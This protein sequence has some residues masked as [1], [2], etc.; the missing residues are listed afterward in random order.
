MLDQQRPKG[1]EW[2]IVLL[3]AIT[4]GMVG[5]DR[6][7]IVYLFP[8]IIPEFNLSNT[9]AGAI[10]S[11]LALT[12]AV[13]AWVLGNVS[14]K[15]GRKKVL[16]PSIIFFSLMSWVTALSK[17]LGSMLV[18][19]GLLGFGEGGVFSATVASI[20]EESSPKR[21]GLNIGF[22]QSFFPLMGIGL[23]AI[24]ATQLAQIFSWRPVFFIV[25][26]PGII[27][28]IIIIFYMREPRSTLRNTESPS[29]SE[30]ESVGEKDAEKLGLFA[31]FKYRNIWLSTVISCLF[32]N[33][34]F[35]F[36]AFS[37]LFLTEIRGLSLTSVGL[38]LSGWGFGGFIGMILIPAL[39]DFIGRRPTMVI[40][41]IIGGITTLLFAVADPNASL[42]FFILLIA[43]IFGWG[44]Y[45]LF[46]A[47]ITTESVPAKMAGTAV[48]I[49]TAI[50][51]IFGAMLMPIIA[52]GLAD[53]YGLSYPMFLAG[54]APIIV[55]IIA[56]FYIETA[57]RIVARKKGVEKADAAV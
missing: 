43:G 22:F 25:G 37:P 48:G 46:L 5:L 45:P 15:Y 38:I 56:L 32:M 10:T 26:I 11:V 29:S 55:G 52:G 6:L 2:K 21:K 30:S 8:I 9:A 18:I 51:E 54:A 33:W 19:R 20:A 50:G 27:L 13:A 7:V 53:M 39:S 31:P 28:A 34:L 36:S 4:W 3:L 35:V 42:L 44:C 14:D 24:I 41:A 1:Y 57:P 23:G 49:P 40:S 47:V 12:W 16:V 17:G